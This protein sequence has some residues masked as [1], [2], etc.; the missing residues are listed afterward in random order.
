TLNNLQFSYSAILTCTVTGNFN[1]TGNFSLPS[2]G[3]VINGTGRAF[4]QGNVTGGG[5]GGTFTVEMTGTG[6]LNGFTTNNIVINTAGVVSLGPTNDL[7]GQLT[8]TAGTLNLA[9]NLT[10]RG[11]TFT[12]LP[13]F[14]FTGAGSLVFR[15]YTFSNTTHIITT[16]G[17][18]WPN[19]VIINP[20]S[21]NTNT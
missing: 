19:S 5:G 8:L 12:I 1:L 4:V 2:G 17:V 10:K 21:S 6:T 16:N 9:N 14:T 7:G 11:S 20:S 13:G 3:T 15:N 18:S